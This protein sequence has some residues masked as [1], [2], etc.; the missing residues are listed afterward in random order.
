MF[1]TGKKPMKVMRTILSFSSKA[2]KL[3]ETKR[4]DAYQSAFIDETRLPFMKYVVGDVQWSRFQR[5]KA[6]SEERKQVIEAMKTFLPRR[7]TQIPVL[8]ASRA[9]LMSQSVI[10]RSSVDR[11]PVEVFQSLK[12]SAMEYYA[13]EESQYDQTVK[14][15]I[16]ELEKNEEQKQDGRRGEDVIDKNDMEFDSLAN[17]PTYKKAEKEFVADIMRKLVQ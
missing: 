15:I 2:S 4:L 6:T 11:T 12:D 10:R 7:I 9:V 13:I 3:R 14:E 5:E 8:D 16:S 17:N 1:A